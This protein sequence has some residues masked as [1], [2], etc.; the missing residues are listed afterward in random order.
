MNTKLQNILLRRRNDVEIPTP[1]TTF[2][3]NESK[4][5]FSTVQSFVSLNST[6]LNVDSVEITDNNKI[7]ISFNNGDY[8][9]S[10]D[11]DEL[12]F[13]V[14]NDITKQ[15]DVINSIKEQLS[16]YMKVTQNA[17]VS[18]TNRKSAIVATVCKNFETLG[19]SMSQNLFN[20][21]MQSSDE[22]IE[23]FYKNYVPQIKE[24]VGANVEYNPMYPNFPK[25]VMEM[26][27]VELYLNAIIH[28]W[29]FGTLLPDYEKLDRP[30]LTE[31]TNYK[32]LDVAKEGELEQIMS[33]LMA[34]TVSVGAA[35]KEDLTTFA[36]NISNWKDYIPSDGMPNK[37]NM[38]YVASM[39]LDEA[40]KN[41]VK[42]TA[43]D[44]N[45]MF[46][47][48][49][50]ILRFIVSQ[51][52]YGKGENAEKADVSLDRLN[53]V[54]YGNNIGKMRNLIM[55]LL[56]ETGEYAGQ[57]I[58]KYRDA[59]TMIAQVVHPGK[60][61]EK[62]P[63]A[64]ESLVGTYELEK[65]I[66]PQL[67]ELKVYDAI[68][69]LPQIENKYNSLVEEKCKF[70]DRYA[71]KEPKDFIDGKVI[72]LLN[73]INA[74]KTMPD[75]IKKDVLDIINEFKTNVVLKGEH[76]I[77]LALSN[78][79][80]DEKYTQLRYEQQRLK[81][82]T[83]YSKRDSYY[84]RYIDEVKSNVEATQVSI[85]ELKK[86]IE[87]LKSVDVTKLKS[88]KEILTNLNTDIVANRRLE[89]N[90]EIEPTLIKIQAIDERN[91]RV[92]QKLAKHMNNKDYVNAINLLSQYPGV[93]ARKLDEL[94]RKC[95]RTDDV[96]NS[97]EKV[98]DQVSPT[99]LLQLKAHIDRRNEEPGYRA[100]TFAGLNS[101][102]YITEKTLEPLP[103]EICER[104]DEI[105]TKAL[106]KEFSGKPGFNNVYIDSQF[107]KQIIP[108]GI[109]SA[110]KGKETYVRGSRFAL[111]KADEKMARENAPAELE[112]TKENIS[113][114]KEKVNNIETSIKNTIDLIKSVPTEDV[115][116]KA[117][118]ISSLTQ[119]VEDLKKQLKPLE[120]DLYAA[121]THQKELEDLLNKEEPKYVRGFIWWTNLPSDSYDSRVDIDLS[122]VLYDNDCKY[123]KH[124]SYTNLR[125]GGMVHSG[126]IT[127]GG[128]VKGKG[129][130]EFIDFDP[131]EV[132]K[133]GARYISF[134][135]NSF[136]GQHFKEM[137]NISFGWM[138]R[139]NINKGEIFEPKTVKQKLDL[140]SDKAM[141]VP[142]LFDCETKEFIWT[143]MNLN[144]GHCSNV[145]NTIDK[146]QALIKSMVDPHKENL[147]TLIDLNIAANGGNIVETTR[148][149]QSGDTAFVMDYPKN[150]ID[151]VNYIRPMD[152]DIITNDLM[153]EATKDE[154]EK[155]SQVEDKEIIDEDINR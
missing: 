127:N 22:D 74:S 117:K 134:Q 17:V 87:E 25:Q 78:R 68:E 106:I 55:E 92:E 110:T 88:S 21:L 100:F 72:Q 67:K 102:M 94:L 144:V 32:Y 150:K 12:K 77:N 70:K 138:E 129:V 73:S 132:L 37:E 90:K 54:Y 69:N 136:T 123:K 81:D 46:K 115:N 111:E 103:T 48:P 151:G 120:E 93:F 43:K 16:S 11:N 118:E 86:N 135:V 131:E 53:K 29:S 39:V 3:D 65:S 6:N 96:L 34:S 5:L 124:V 105:C 57:D 4:K 98:A 38:A 24:L 15:S 27:D 97:F 148:E 8:N 63:H 28:Y 145:E 80:L 83:A 7:I 61:A 35:E 64:V 58:S 153:R 95:I 71:G 20:A 122:A 112:E 140:S 9:L 143:D 149:L 76:E 125:S 18:E 62:Y 89:I 44:F 142:V 154:I 59:W 91:Q 41:G 47:T 52:T 101:E 155:L 14:I 50:D 31:R 60:Y 30:E 40:N 49:T 75:E 33:N 42:A 79:T 45:G 23:K 10:L 82:Y 137:P 108:Q 104:V 139:D 66:K 1:N 84:K 147:R 121:E 19:Y 128:P 126:D 130:A 119:S 133:S 114:L 146:T 107:D 152:I 56:D 51:S 13:D 116:K 85:N 2:L 109:R 141:T 113:V 36:E 99:V 26:S